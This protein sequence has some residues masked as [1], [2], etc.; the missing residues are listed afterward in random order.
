MLV[1]GL[2]L[3]IYLKDIYN[4]EQYNCD[5]DKAKKRNHTIFHEKILIFTNPIICT[6][7]HTNQRDA[8][9][10]VAYIQKPVSSTYLFKCYLHNTN[11]LITIRQECE[12]VAIL[13]RRNVVKQKM[14]S[15]FR[16]LT[17]PQEKRPELRCIK[18]DSPPC[19]PS[20]FANKHRTWSLPTVFVHNPQYHYYGCLKFCSPFAH[21]CLPGKLGEHRL[22]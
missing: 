9:P 20:L 10:T 3:E 13:I 12:D 7:I 11:N 4:T 21:I 19:S 6:C 16:L 22:I 2:W 14:R 8:L 17:R 5:M 15:T 1:P 18:P